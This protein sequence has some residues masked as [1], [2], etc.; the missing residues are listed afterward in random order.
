[1]LMAG[2]EEEE[3]EEEAAIRQL[4]IEAQVHGF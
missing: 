2:E 4:E 3:E 1:M